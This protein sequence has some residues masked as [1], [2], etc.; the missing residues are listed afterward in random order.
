[1][2]RPT[3]IEVIRR[4]FASADLSQT[5]T[6]AAQ[7]ASGDGDESNL[8]LPPGM[9]ELLA[10]RAS[11]ETSA[12]HAMPHP[13]QIVRVLPW[14]DEQG[15]T[16][17]EYLAVLLDA[18]IAVGKWRGW[19]VGR[20]ASYACEW[21]LVLGPEEGLRDPL[22][23]LVQT[24]NPLTLT[25]SDADRVLAE[26]TEERH[27]A[28]R[29]LAR[30]YDERRLPAP[31]TDHRIG[32][33]L[34][35]ELSDGTG[36][37]TG[38]PL[39]ADDP[40]REYQN[41]YHEAAL[42]LSRR[43]QTIPALLS[44]QSVVPAQNWPWLARWLE[45][46]KGHWLRPTALAATL[47]LVPFV[48]IQLWQASPQSTS[49]PGSYISGERIHEY[50]T[51]NPGQR[52]RQIEDILRARGIAPEIRHES[53][54]TVMIRGDLTALPEGERRKLRASLELPVS[55]EPHI[56][57]LLVPGPSIKGGTRP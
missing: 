47:L 21:D 28:V 49:G 48:A 44:T 55:G 33:H 19:L 2:T 31:L 36:V 23:Q 32:V 30:D 34:A 52:A 45:F 54:G 1:M 22:C 6:P 56:Q 50:Q 11:A 38:T 35:R 29:R 20:D 24:W 27:I 18:E 7:I 9:R 46:G 37:V 53:G 40:R 16:Y 39:A 17:A 3:P 12:F 25:I 15:R 4:R 8:P 41:L 26:L 10:Q 57:I 42:G 5:C 51:E 14:P 13:G 43:I